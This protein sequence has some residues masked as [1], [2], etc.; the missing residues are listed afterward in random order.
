MNG[1]GFQVPVPG[2]GVVRVSRMNPFLQRL[3]MPHLERQ[4]KYRKANNH[5]QGRSGFIRDAPRAALD[6]MDTDNLKAKK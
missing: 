5:G 1:E 3:H 2:H 4:P 6:L